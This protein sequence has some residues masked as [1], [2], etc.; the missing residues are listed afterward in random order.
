MFGYNVLKYFFFFYIF[1]ILLDIIW[2]K[3]AACIQNHDKL[4]LTC[5]AVVSTIA[6]L[7][8]IPANM[9]T[10]NYVM[11]CMFLLGRQNENTVSFVIIYQKN[12]IP[13]RLVICLWWHSCFSAVL[14]TSL[15][16]RFLCWAAQPW[17][18]NL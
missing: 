9:R 11:F 14:N 4:T 12:V 13:D 6:H 10:V 1:I 8:N 15:W 17:V 2:K 3:N 16:L 18:G 7:Q 5:K